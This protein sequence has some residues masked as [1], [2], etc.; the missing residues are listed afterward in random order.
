MLLGTAAVP[1]GIPEIAG[2]QNRHAV[3]AHAPL[4]ANPF[5][6]EL[7]P[8]E[9]DTRALRGFSG[10]CRRARAGERGRGS[11]ALL[12]HRLRAAVSMRLPA[13]CDAIAR[14]AQGTRRNGQNERTGIS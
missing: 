12:R 8:G 2:K 5:F 13:G 3:L 1:G 11:A 10:G 14:I 9:L 6:A 7:S 4:R